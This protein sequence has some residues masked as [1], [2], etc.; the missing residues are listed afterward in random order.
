MSGEIVPGQVV[1][2]EIVPRES[3]VPAVPDSG[4][5]LPAIPDGN[6][7]FLSLGLAVTTLA[8]RALWLKEKIWVLQALFRRNADKASNMSEMCDAAEVEPRFTALIMEGA[9]SLRE[10]AEASGDLVDA[11]DAMQMDAQGF[12]DAHQGEYG[13]IYEVAQSMG[14]QQPKPGFN[15][16]K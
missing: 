7:G 4:D 6:L 14:V 16:V 2:G 12:N 5:N 8:A 3:Y 10:V 15:E 1:S 9:T 11:A 13:G